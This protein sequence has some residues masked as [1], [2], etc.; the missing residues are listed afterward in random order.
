MDRR[1]RVF[2]VVFTACFLAADFI[3]TLRQ[4]GT[5]SGVLWWLV[6]PLAGW[7]VLFVEMRRTGG[8]QKSG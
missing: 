8:E 4:T 1:E 7:A 3:G 6:L 5:G 2:T